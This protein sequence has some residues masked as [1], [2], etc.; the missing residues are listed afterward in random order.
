MR[1]KGRFDTQVS[2]IGGPATVRAGTAHTA[3]L[4][5][6]ANVSALRRK[7]FN[8]FSNLQALI[9]ERRQRY[10]TLRELFAGIPP[11]L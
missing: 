10:E 9:S 6:F 7:F 5:E 8:G 4:Y 11:P 1:K 2:R 3:Q